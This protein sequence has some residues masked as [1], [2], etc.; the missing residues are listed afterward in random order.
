MSLNLRMTVSEAGREIV[1][2]L[3]ENAAALGTAA[4]VAGVA[5]ALFAVLRFH[6]DDLIERLVE[7]EGRVLSTE[8]TRALETRTHAIREFARRWEGIADPRQADWEHEAGVIAGADPIYRAFEWRDAAF[9]PMWST[10]LTARLPGAELDSTYEADRV[11]GVAGVIQ[12]PAGVVS[13]SFP[14]PGGRRMIMFAAPLFRGGE[15][16][17]VLGA[18][19]RASDLIDAVVKPATQRGYSVAVRE[20]PYHIFG[21]LASVEGTAAEHWKRSVAVQSGELVWAVDYWPGGE[22]LDRLR[23]FGPPLVLLL[24]LFAAAYAGVLARTLELAR[25][26]A[27]TAGSTPAPGSEAPEIISAA[28]PPQESEV[29][30]TAS[31]PEIVTESQSS[32]G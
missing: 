14:G 16:I 10:P 5:L 4:L 11:S 24:G 2:W 20:G 30:S 26:A 29:A 19:T 3:R 25:R 13:A 28:G 17:G 15:R 12:F 32:E 9:Q 7:S 22:L 1:R 8:M 31:H 23:S 6:E 27:S 21:P 18:V